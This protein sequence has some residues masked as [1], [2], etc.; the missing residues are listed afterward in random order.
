LC[1]GAKRAEQIEIGVI[2]RVENEDYK[3]NN[4]KWRTADHVIFY[5]K[6]CCGILT[7]FGYV[8]TRFDVGGVNPKYC[9]GCQAF[10]PRDENKGGD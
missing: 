4:C 8:C 2:E 7:K 1:F 5:E 10:E 3:F 9:V 6:Y